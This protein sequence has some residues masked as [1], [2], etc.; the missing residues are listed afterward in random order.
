MT[1]GQ[2]LFLFPFPGV[3]FNSVYHLT[4]L[5]SF[6]SG[7]YVVV[8]D[9][10][11]VYLPNVSAANPGKRIEYVSSSAISLYRDQFFPYCA[12]GCDMKSP[13]RGT[14]FRFPL[15]NT[16]QALN[17]KLSK[18]AYLEDDISSMFVQLYEEGVLALLF[19]KSVLSIEMYVWDAELPE[20]RKIYSCSINSTS[21]NTV[22]HRQ[23]LL[24]LSNSANYSVCETDAYSLDFLRE[25]V[26]GNRSEKRTDTFYV[27]Q[28]MA[29]ASSRIGSFAA[30]ASKEYDI[31]LL[32]WASVAA[33][34]SDDSSSDEVLKL[35][36]AFCFLPLPVKTG[37]S[38]QIN[39]YFEVSSNRRGIWY[40]ADMDRSGRIRSLWNRL[41]L[42]DVVA[43]TFV[44]LLLA[45]QALLGPTTA[46]YSLWPSGSFEEPWNILV[47]HIYRNIVDSPVLYSNVDGGKWVTPVEAF[48]HDMEFARSRELGEALVQLE[49]PIVHLP[50]AL[51]DMLLKCAS[52][53]QLKVVTPDTVRRC[54][55]KSRTVSTLSRSYKLILL[56]YC[57]ED[58]IDT[59]VGE[60]AY[61]LPLLPLASGDFGLFSVVS[62]GTSYFIC[63]DLEYI[64]LQKISDTVID[65]NISEK[66]LTRLSAIAKASSANLIVFNVKI[67]LQ[68]FPRFVP[69][70]WKYKTK[71][72]WDPKDDSSYP[73]ST[74]FR[75]FWQYLRGQCEALSLFGDWPILPSLSGHLHRPYRES[76]LLNVEQLSDKMRDLL[77]KIGC[78]VLDS[79]Y[80][81]EHPDLV[82]YVCDAN[83]AGVLESIYNV[84]STNDSIRQAFL[85]NLEA[86]ERDD[87][88]RFLLDPKW[89][90]GNIM[91][92]SDI[93]SCKRLPIY[94]VFPG[95]SADSIQYSDLENPRK[96][97][98][99]YNC[100]ECFLCGEFISS[101]SN[102]EEEVL[103]RYY[104]I[105][106]M[107]K[108]LFYKQHVLNRVRELPDEA[109]DSV[110]VSILQELPQ[111]CVEDSSFK[112]G[113]R[114]LEFVSTSSGSLKC[115]AA[116]YD[117][118]NEE[119][120]ALL[121]DSDCFPWGVFQESD[122]LDMLQGLGLRTSV[123]TEAVVQAAR[124]VEHL[125]HDDQQ[126]AH[127][128][129]KVLLSYLEV[130]ALKWQPN[131]PK[132][133]ERTMNRMFSR[134]AIA[135][136]HRTSKSDLEKFWND[137]RMIC[138]C[139]V[140]VSSPYQALPW[141]VVSS[142][143]AP[144]KLVRLSTDLWLVSAS[145]RILDGECS[146]TALSYH[147]G[148]S[149]PPGGSVIAA[150]LL[151]LGKNNDI[152]TD[153]VLRQ[154]LA[155][156]M[157]R[158]YS[159]LTSMIGSDEMD[160]VKA[161]LEGCRWIWVGDGFATLDEV[162]LGGP[163]HLAPYIRVIPV[164]L[165]V[166]RDLFLELGV[167]EFLKPSD[168]AN[169]LCRMAMT[170]GST[171]LDAHE[172]RAALLIAQHLAE[173]Q[174]YEEQI[175][176]YLPDLSCRL[177]N[178]TDLVYNDAPWLLDSE[179][180]H[181]SFAEA[182]GQHEALTTRL[183]HILEMYADGP[184]ILFELVQNAEDARA[185]EVIFLLDKTQYGTS[186]VLSP[187]MADWQGPSLYCFNN[188][189]FSP[190]DLYAISRIGQES[191]LDKPFAVGRFGLGF[192][193]VY[194]FTD[195]P[196]FVSGENIVMFDPHA[197]NLPGISPSHPGL[198]IKFVGRRILEQFPDQFSPFLHFG[199]DLQQSFPGTL[200][201]FP[202]RSVS[203]ASR[204]QIKKEKYLPED[205]TSLFSSFAEVVS[206]TI[207]FLRNVKTISIFVKEGA[208]CEMQLLH[209]VQKQCVTDPEAE[210]NAFN[211][212][213]NVTQGNQRD[214]IDKDQF[215]DK[216]SRSIDSDLPWKCQ[217]LVVTEQSS[218]GDKSHLW[219][220]SE[221][222]GSG[223]VKNHSAT[224]D[225]KS[226]K[227]IPWAC[228]ASHLNSVKVERE[229]DS[230]T[231]AVDSVVTT[232]DILQIPV[233]SVPLK[234]NFEGRA[235]CFLPLPINT[236]LPVHVNGYFELS[237]NRRDIWFGNDM[238]GG[239]KKRSDWNMYL[240]ED[241]AA[242][243]YGHLLEKVALE[244]GPSDLFF[245]LWPPTLRLEPWA[246]MVQ[247]L[248]N[249]IADFGLRVLYTKARGGQWISTKQAIFP[250]FTF[251]KAH[252]LVEA[253]SDA[254]LPV[255]TIPQPLVEKFM[256]VCP[257][258]HFLTP[259][260]LRTLLIRRKREFRGKSEM[261]LTLEYCLLDLR[262]PV[263][264][265]SFYG[266]PLVPLS[267][268]LFT[269]FE[270]RGVSERIFVAHGDEYGLLK[271]SVPHQLVDYRISG[272]VHRKLCDI[273]RTED[274][275]ISFLTC[276]LLEKLF[277]RILPAN[278]LL[279][280]QV[281]WVPGH[282]GQPSLEWMRILWSY[283]KS[284]CDDLSLFSRWPILPVGN[285]HLLR[286]VENS[287]V[288]KDDGWSENM[289]SLFLRV[290]CVI[291]RSDLLVE[292]PQLEHYV[293][294]PTASGV[295]NAFL[296]VAVKLE[297]VEELFLDAAEGELHE[298]RSFILQS[299]W[300]S[301]DS[302]D[303]M[304]IDIIKHI[305]MFESFR[306]RKLLSLR[307]STAWLKP[308]GVRED[309]LD[310]DFV[311]M[312]SEK[313]R[314]ILRKYLMIREPSKVQF[315]KGYVLNRMPEFLAQQ[316]ILS[317]ILYD[318]RLLVEE[319]ETS[320]AA[321]SAIPFVL[322]RNGTWQEPSRLYDPRVPELQKVLHSEA[323]FPSDKFSSHETLETLVYLGLRQNL[324]FTG[325]LDCARSVSMLHDSR[326]SE[327]IIYGR[328]LLGSLDAL[329]IKLLAEVGEGS[330]N[331]SGVAARSN[332]TS[333]CNVGEEY[334]ADSCETYFKDGQDIDSLMGNVIDD[335]AG[336]E[337]WSELKA[338]GWCPV[339]V[340]PPLRGLPW[341]VSRL[342][343]AAPIIVRP[344]SQMWMVSSKM[345]IL[346]GECYSIY[347]QH[348][349][350]WL[351]RLDVDVLSA[352]LIGL[353]KSY[354]QLKLH[355]EME[356]S[357]EAA[358]QEQIPSLYTK[359]QEYLSDDDFTVL[360]SALDGVNWVWIG[361]DFVSPKSLAFDSPVK[362]SPYLYVSFVHC[363]LEAIADSCSDRLMFE[364]SNNPLLIPD[365]SG[366]LM[367]AGDLVFNDAPWMESSTLVSKQYVHPSISHD[368]ANRLGIQS[369]RCLSLVSEEMTKDLPCMEY[370]RICDLLGLYG[371]NDFLLF[372][373]LELADCCKAKKL[374]LIFD[375]REHPHQSLL[376]HNLA[377]FQGPAL[378][379]ILEGAIL[380][381]E[382]VAS[383]QFLPPWSLRDDTLNY[384]LGLLSCYFI[385][386]VPSVVS[387]GSLYMFDPRGLALAVPS[388][389]GPAAKMFSLI[390]TD[391]TERFRDQFSPMLISGNMPWSTSD[392]T[393]IRM[394]LSSECM[395]DGIEGG[396]ERMT[397]IFD[398]FMEHA[399]RALLFLKSVLQVSLS[400]W[401]D[402]N[403]QPCQDYS[404]DV[405][406]SC[407]V[408]RNPFSEKK[409]KKF[410][411]SSLFGS[412]NAAIKLHIIDVNLNQ[413][414][415]L[416]TD[417]WLIVLCL[418]SGQTR[419]MALDRRYLAYNLTP[420]AGVAAH[421]LRNG[422]PVEACLSSSTMSPLPL[423]DGISI[424][425]TIL[426]CFLVRHNQGRYLF[427]YQDTRSLVEA[428]P[429][430]GNQLIEAWN[431]ELMSCVRDSYIK[432]VLEM[433]KLRREPSNSTLESIAARA[434]SMALS[435]YGHQIYS[436]WPRSNGQALLEDLP[437]SK[438]LKAD[439]VCLIEQV[440]RPFYG[441]LLDLPVW[442]LYSGNLVKAEEGMFLSQ[443][444]SGVGDSLLPATVCAFVKEHYPV[445]SVPWELV[446]EIQAVGVRVREIRPKMVRDLLRVSSTSFV[447]CSVDTC[448]DVLEYCLSD[449]ESQEPLDLNSPNISTNNSSSESS[450]KENY[451][452][453]SS[454]PSV[455]IRSLQGLRGMSNHGPA[456][457]GGDAIEM[458][459][460][461]GKALFDFG[462]GVVEDI[463][464][465]GPLPQRDNIT[466]LSSDGISRIGNRR[467][468]TIATELKGLPF[469]TATNHLTRL[470]VTE[471]W[472]GN[473]EEQTL[474]ISLAAKFI[475]AKVLERP[476]L[477]G[478]LS[479]SNLQSLL[480]LQSFSLHLLANHMR[481]I[482]HENW[483]SHV[484]DSNTAPWFSWENTASSGNEGGP[485]PEWLRLFWKSFSGPM[486]D[487]S[488]FSD[489]PLIPAFLGRPVLCRVR[490]RH[491][492]FIPP[493]I[494][495][496]L[497]TSDGMQL[498][499]IETDL[500]GSATE[501]GPTQP[502]M[503]GF[504]VMENKY[505]WLCSF[506][507]Q[508]NI[509]MLDSAF[510]ECAGPCHCFP[511]AGRSLGQVVASKLVAA[512]HAGYFPDLTSFLARDELF[513]LFASDFPSSGSEYV[514]EEL[515]VLRDLPIYK[516]V[517]G[518]YTRLDGQDHCVISSSTFLKPYD[519][520]CLFSTTDSVGSS[521]VR[522][523]GVP[524]L[525]DQQIL[526][527]FGLPGFEGKPQ[528][529]QEDILIYLYTNWQDL[530]Q[531]T[532]ILEALKETNFVRSADE[533]SVH[534]SKP[535]DLFDPGDILLTSIFS[536]ERKKF[537][538]ERFVADGWLR[539]L[540]KTGLRTATEM[541]VVI[542]CA[543]KVESMGAEC[544]NPVGFLD[545]FETDL[546]NLKNE[547]S[548]E[549]WSLAE[550]LVRAIFSNF[551][552][553]YGNNFCNLLGKIACIP[554]E[555]GFP[556]IGGKKGGKRVLCSYSEAIVLKDWPLAWSCAPILS[557]R[558]VP[559]EYSWGALQ[560]RSPPAFPT[561]L[562][563]L[564]VIGRNYGEDT[565]AHWPT[566][567]GLM[568]IDEAS[569]EVLKYLDK[570]WDSL[571]SSDIMVLQ[572]VAFI[573]AANGTRLVTASS[574][575]ARL[576]INLSPF[577]FELPPQYLSFV[578]I[579][580]DLGL[581]DTLSV[582]SAKDLLLN[583]QK[584]CG[585]QRLNPNELRAVLEILD[586]V[587][588]KSTEAN[589]SD[590]PTWGSEAIVPDDDSRLVHA[591]SCIYV[592][593]Y[594]SKC[595]K[596]I[597]S[598]RLRFVHRDLPERICVA[599]GIKKLSDVVVEELHHEEHLQCLDSIGSVPLAVIKQKLLSKS[600]QAAVWSI[601]NTVASDIP[602]F[603]NL[604]LENIRR[605]LESV[606]EKLQF[607]KCLQT[608]F[609]LLPK[610][611]DI[612]R[613]AKESILPEWA[614]G[615][616]NQALYFIDRLKTCMLIAE[617]P[618]YVSVLD[619]VA[620]VVSQALGSPIPLPIGSLILC[621]EESETALLNVLKLC[622]NER[623]SG[624]RG[625][626]NSFL[627]SEILPRDAVQV[628]FHPLR[629]FYR[630]EI[631]AWRSQNGEKLKYGRVLDDV[632]PSAGQA[633]YRFN[634]ETSPGVTEPLLSSHVF[635]FR[636]LSTRNEDDR[637]VADNRI[638]VEQPE[639]SEITKSVSS[640]VCV[641]YDIFYLSRFVN[642]NILILE[643]I[644]I[645]QLDAGLHNQ[646]LISFKLLLMKTYMEVLS[647]NMLQSQVG[648]EN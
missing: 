220:T 506:L 530:Q 71:V 475:H 540:R 98:P 313:E 630:G 458:V 40:G 543:K 170:K 139:P 604:A 225:A 298:L 317:S 372:D 179:H 90:M 152:V 175:K 14:L 327:A 155:L 352:Q 315:Y 642:R 491:L 595:V 2:P 635:S 276:H 31:H 519:D 404:V 373:L 61:D 442:Q 637:I 229:L 62:K 37:M 68:L 26:I 120:Y 162:V 101:L 369:L 222:L 65:H 286:L 381:R 600:F 264:S 107:G 416:V 288:I 337:F 414:G 81:V 500:A 291:L 558:V 579:L 437:S 164:D 496:T 218:Y 554:A 181:N 112:E 282:Q 446:T 418:G 275:N 568:T 41:L 106:R 466:G 123:S 548:M 523:L 79:N 163:L 408:A 13:F 70:D 55:R 560:L 576:A 23:A 223:R 144:P 251:D 24:R 552:V 616:K 86:G 59:D 29:S 434:V 103:S 403:P 526:V 132:V 140:L 585:Y 228:V 634:V 354:A 508:C 399:S 537:P 531:D 50:N 39:G 258:L 117:P 16:D 363:V 479:N 304:H 502:Y 99:P 119:L 121:E 51:L 566:A 52:T 105:E 188:S 149:L 636:S 36:R 426:G 203:A 542:E 330:Y 463:G 524:E 230:D 195:I 272:V 499:T 333:A 569:F 390:G 200:F 310:D 501:P 353:S 364:S 283:L 113:L 556:N 233:T 48:L 110:M 645:V 35:G 279:A 331:E 165:A 326:D 127:S 357:F 324:G 94:R 156:A 478:I 351:K 128:R 643:R 147:L 28:T 235:F 104:G 32:P 518:T 444:G 204:S 546:F 289:S 143:V 242:P 516:T 108:A 621:A 538:G 168:Y 27:V 425:V 527:K 565:L 620:L 438:V 480:K 545:D 268:E 648:T 95:E 629:P 122:M 296:S 245:S 22:W 295:L 9:P 302:L 44:Q 394:P 30:A 572:R 137:L 356:P 89:Y 528:P 462:R 345:H 34:M 82:H 588:S 563:H 157:P 180:S 470:G 60:H 497:S 541:D 401:E 323:F 193:C 292:H 5:P 182:F 378:V 427:K 93:R 571:S 10:Q 312:E 42:E 134:A 494:G 520:R 341:A 177:V 56:E 451:E 336:E 481:L 240:L 640:Q 285:N 25:A 1:T 239:G 49:V 308:D 484:I 252:D 514:M 447:L 515:E 67:L 591:M 471:V 255:V 153:S 366:V 15:R 464:R 410:Q 192:N 359:M 578:K 196:A 199:C 472:V 217:K 417:R 172:I 603:D 384:G 581:Q 160:I 7:K 553:L 87:L 74:W 321:L 130:N 343:V 644:V 452:V 377:E 441:R 169:I 457:S 504:K 303:S 580:K 421:I 17:S 202:L 306:T 146:S 533:L 535:K 575:F 633:L 430:A 432:L 646:E 368:L 267:N 405:D 482:F 102:A 597:D 249:F 450:Y 517:T 247:K 316:E 440:I 574:L 311:R 385:S 173:V 314:V 97:L 138:W 325:L 75:L 436:F 347:L 453:G 8:F 254:G 92:D 593:S 178:A 631:V 114:Y 154:E 287:N 614:G 473:K 445:F 386:D 608:R 639:G 85:H 375:K 348:K 461:L 224:I 623:L 78:K 241:V 509:P 618:S 487:L 320:K 510:L 469:P 47:E 498:V 46:Y 428:Q 183:K 346:D 448:V 544:T 617:P 236:G 69:D 624:C 216:L 294:S 612:T 380:N 456:T 557:S 415:V 397:L 265:D 145:M 211:H 495:E 237:S 411:L 503:L 261:I 116:L 606:A 290:G 231:H 197:C 371:N 319:D 532:S 605:S 349:L 420:V 208:S 435:A 201:R 263:Q 622:S 613:V 227:F 72:S 329:T 485:S 611:L 43:P 433:Q 176:I 148:W 219:L 483:V 393:I 256:E 382:E 625:G 209:R 274:F 454:S 522:A 350:G 281:T 293:Q 628:Q 443:P 387:G 564:K 259:H 550:T 278:W 3:G 355:S 344:K 253:L 596:Y 370:A 171:P 641:D 586:F 367:Y 96:Y 555:K 610:S 80:G 280:K 297:K 358:L 111:L 332:N 460:S 284:N 561:V 38:V 19:L 577:A 250:D 477:A 189:V 488:L 392:S 431:R 559:P 573:P 88:R 590:T 109:R 340:D 592:D 131:P 277:V 582:E 238:A 300:F 191:K 602:A 66:I 383:L 521:F 398:K 124:Q 413:G 77:V 210:T 6:V 243:A 429:D 609:L 467:L 166:F 76:K 567:T 4:D 402:G 493:P 100:P 615:S 594:G 125:M 271:D 18:Q 601:V 207:L 212:M 305:P 627:G 583:L 244:I 33:C 539:I 511:T 342:E 476:I 570:V 318:V 234:R 307:K 118:R 322:A 270:K 334:P 133:D 73:T 161:V 492:V 406:S 439:W 11:G 158:I 391:L 205:V 489:W 63:N 424:P 328:R 638:K 273:A 151:E 365:S 129:G 507:N 135:F 20:P 167:R 423:S 513:A 64:L 360:N 632:R 136:K 598:S 490:E 45:V 407:A 301:D 115:P 412:S 58:L 142:M 607:V 299:K 400:T 647:S 53:F 468:L 126:R 206:E 174:F 529:E 213:F 54:L 335:R 362:F 260:L 84:V 422:H 194:H 12:F 159:I 215:L 248:Y 186:S 376:Q 91:T 339:F 269:A 589:T 549:I 419:N 184:G 449:I 512:K 525:H 395:K 455:S 187:E 562:K 214:E 534:L 57:L 465:A 309:L 388:S 21:D 338:I 389:R 141:P 626:R 257:S 536:G 409:W 150:Q 547:I 246:S 262:I 361:D 226:H 551:A 379:A 374:H 396:M 459:S 232:P 599:L 266:L 584:A 83:G 221:C 619:V 474:M 505:P 185:S 198:R 486:E 190:Q 587:S